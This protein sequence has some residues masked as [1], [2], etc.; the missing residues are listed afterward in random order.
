MACNRAPR[1]MKFSTTTRA[2]RSFGPTFEWE[3][4]VVVRAAINSFLAHAC[5]RTQ[6]TRHQTHGSSTMMQPVCFKKRPSPLKRYLY[7]SL[8]FFFGISMIAGVGVFPRRLEANS[9]P[10]EQAL[11]CS[12]AQSTSDTRHERQE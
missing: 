7:T 6:G 12:T 9:T 2:H 10:G 11:P 4:A 8:R 5:F 1:A 3:A